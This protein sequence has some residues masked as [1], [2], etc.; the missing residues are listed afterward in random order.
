MKKRARRTKL[1]QSLQREMCRIIAMPFTIQSALEPTG[2]STSA[3]QEWIRRGEAGE[4][5]FAQFAEAIMH[6]RGVGKI[7]IAR[8]S[9]DMMTQSR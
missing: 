8:F 9:L 1:S 3:F 6:A 4:R 7:R 2:L 5:P